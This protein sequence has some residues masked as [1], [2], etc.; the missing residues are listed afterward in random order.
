M[1][2]SH[3]R[4]LLRVPRHNIHKHNLTNS[5]LSASNAAYIFM[6]AVFGSAVLLLIF[7]FLLCI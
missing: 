5:N 4:Q 2:F 3:L 1:Q 6:E 7:F